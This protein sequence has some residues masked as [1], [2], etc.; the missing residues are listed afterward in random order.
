MHMDKTGLSLRA[1]EKEEDET[2]TTGKMSV[3]GEFV[4]DKKQ[5]AG[6]NSDS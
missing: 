1:E 3:V 5:K 2:W 4:N 6:K